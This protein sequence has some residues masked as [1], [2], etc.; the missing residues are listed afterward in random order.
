MAYQ[1]PF[2]E[3]T[4]LVSGSTYPTSNLYFKQVR[5]IESC[6]QFHENSEDDFIRD[7]VRVMKCKFEKYWK[8]YSDIVAIGAVLDSRMKFAL[9][10]S[11]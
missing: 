3:I 2:Q 10:I 9:R 1:K 8:D 6:L 7:M 5:Q 11:K 4:N